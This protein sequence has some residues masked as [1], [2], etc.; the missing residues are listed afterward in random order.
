M[1]SSC[2]LSL[3]EA[4]EAIL[5]LEPLPP[6]VVAA[7][8]GQRG[9]DDLGHR[10]VVVATTR[11]LRAEP[12][13][14]VTAVEMA[15]RTVVVHLPAVVAVRGVSGFRARKRSVIPRLPMAVMEEPVCPALS[16]EPRPTTPVV[17][18]VVRITTRP[19][20]PNAVGAEVR[21]TTSMAQEMERMHTRA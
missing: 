1:I 12:P 21:K 10:A 6:L 17:V 13:R 3:M 4:T 19:R 5:Y 15:S 7:A 16:L 8:A 14:K 18:A 20:R 2:A 9:V 11:Q